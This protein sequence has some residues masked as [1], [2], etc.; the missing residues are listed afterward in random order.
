MEH[1][2]KK[3]NRLNLFAFLVVVFISFKAVYY[4]FEYFP[5]FIRYLH[6]K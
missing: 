5:S 3:S 4:F 2:D 1:K 6:S